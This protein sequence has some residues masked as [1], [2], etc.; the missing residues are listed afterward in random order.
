METKTLSREVVMVV[1]V[2]TAVLAS[3]LLSIA[4]EGNQTLTVLTA[5]VSGFGLGIFATMV[6]L[7]DK[8]EN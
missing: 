4:F 3:S 5:F 7:Q 6:V 2:L 8:L 1:L